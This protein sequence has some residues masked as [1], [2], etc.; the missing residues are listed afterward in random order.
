M[1]ESSLAFSCSA[2]G[3]KCTLWKDVLSRGNGPALNEKLLR[4]ILEKRQVKGSSGTVVLKDG[5][6]SF[7]P[8]GSDRPSVSR[9]ILYEKKR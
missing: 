6:I 2:E 4:L 3:C 1:Q 8:N 9:S 7:Y 5:M